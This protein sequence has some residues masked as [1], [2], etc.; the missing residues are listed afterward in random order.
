MGRNNL[1]DSVWGLH[2][3]LSVQKVVAFPIRHQ[4]ACKIWMS[5]ATGMPS[6]CGWKNIIDAGQVNIF[7]GFSGDAA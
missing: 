4:R 5:S 2:Y 7:I 6:Q 3:I 1:P